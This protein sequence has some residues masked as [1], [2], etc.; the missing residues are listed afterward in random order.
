MATGEGASLTTT[1]GQETFAEPLDALLAEHFR[2]RAMCDL[3]DRL[4]EDPTGPRSSELARTIL[5]Y[6]REQLPLH[7][8]DEE[9]DL[10]QMLRDRTLAAEA[11]EEA[12]AQ[13]RREHAEDE[14]VAMLVT[15]GLEQ[16]TAGGQ[17]DHAE[18]FASAARAFAEAQRRHVAFENSSILPLARTRLTAKDL[19]RLA[20][21]MA[22]RRRPAA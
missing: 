10:F 15:S 1:P 8:L 14:R 21:R 17:P 20:R 2:Q 19:A 7:V 16:L 13:L 18:E 12:F 9:R 4:A 3:L 22:A 5:T 6:L 11:I